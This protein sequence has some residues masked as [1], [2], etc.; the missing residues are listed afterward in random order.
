MSDFDFDAALA[1]QVDSR[2]E[3]APE[4]EPDP[5][6]H[7]SGEEHVL[8]TD[9]DL[10][11]PDVLGPED[12]EEEEKEE[13]EEEKQEPEAFELDDR[14]AS[15]LKELA[16]NYDGDVTK[17]V[18][19]ALDAQSMIGR[20][21]KEIGELRDAVAEIQQNRQQQP[22]AF[23][24]DL[25]EEID[26]NPDAVAKW[27]LSQ[28]QP[29]IYNAAM[30]SWYEENPREASRFE[31]ALEMEMLRTEMEQRL[32]PAIEPARQ[33]TAARSLAAAQ[34]ELRAVYPDL[35]SILESATEAEV[36]G[37]DATAIRQLQ[38]TNPKAALETIYRW[39]KAGRPYEAVAASPEQKE[40]AR[41]AKRSAAVVSASSTPAREDKGA[42]D[43]LKDFMLTPEPQSVSHG[44]QR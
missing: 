22:Q 18:L 19:N 33:Q 29:G 41:A 25:D 44:L 34:T 10:A 43:K 35:D 37:L 12:E 27:A 39:V 13:E 30:A 16:A 21:S 32:Q 23:P 28:N 24:G 11:E 15:Y 38:E 4:E 26:E 20:Q 3:T 1:A 9:D 31:R 7:E 17:A 6:I 36:S 42:Y 40:A 2:E 8:D 14:T 5:D